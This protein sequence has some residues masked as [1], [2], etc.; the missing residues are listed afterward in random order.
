MKF[1]YSPTS[2]YLSTICNEYYNGIT[3]HYNPATVFA[4]T[5]NLGGGFGYIV[6]NYYDPSVTPTA[7]GA[8][9]MSNAA[10]EALDHS[11]EA[12]FERFISS[13]YGVAYESVSLASDRCM[14][15]NYDDWRNKLR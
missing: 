14:P 13:Q 2:S 7:I 8:Q 6:F 4:D 5:S 12:E 1:S 11:I 15:F 10:N 9:V 3:N